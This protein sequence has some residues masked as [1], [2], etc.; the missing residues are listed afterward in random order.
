MVMVKDSDDLPPKFTESI[1]RTKINEFSPITVSVPN[2][3][4]NLSFS[5]KFLFNTSE[6][7]NE[8]VVNSNNG[9]LAKEYRLFYMEIVFVWSIDIVVLAPFTFQTKTNS[10]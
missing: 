4:D 5:T 8:G 9:A 6:E 2:V 3:F 10:N 1:Y 7:K